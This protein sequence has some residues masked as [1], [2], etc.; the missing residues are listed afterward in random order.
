[1][2]EG[3]SNKNSRLIR[4]GSFAKV[5]GEDPIAGIPVVVVERPIV[6]VPLGGIGIPVHVD[7]KAPL[8]C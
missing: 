5:A 8:L 4:G 1:M 2:E 7:G 6:D 3:F